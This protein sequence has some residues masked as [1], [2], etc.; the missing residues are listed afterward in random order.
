MSRVV[1]PE[2]RQLSS[3]PLFAGCS[4]RQLERADQYWTFIRVEPGR[5]LYRRGE[6]P[7]TLVILITGQAA[8]FTSSPDIGIL[9]PGE[10]IGALASAVTGAEV[11]DAAIAL[12]AGTI[13][14]LTARELTGLTAACPAVAGRLQPGSSPSPDPAPHRKQWSLPTG[15]ASRLS[16]ITKKIA[17]H[18]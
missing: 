16:A 10:C 5:V 1:V 13:A 15:Q 4:P 8:T 2:M 6:H 9:G 17:R 12:T 18:P 11:L 7:D 14:A 3:T